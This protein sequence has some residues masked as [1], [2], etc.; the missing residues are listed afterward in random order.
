MA[1]RFRRCLIALSALLVPVSLFGQANP[2]PPKPSPQAADKKPQVG[3]AAPQSRHFPILLILS[4]T[5]PVWS[6]RI[7]MKGPELLERQG[8]P[9]ITL[10]PGE[11]SQDPAP[12]T[13]TYHAKDTA[14]GADVQVHMVREPCM[15]GLTDTKYTFR[16]E[17]DHAQI[18]TLKGC[19]RIAPDQFPEFKQKNLDDDDPEKKKPGPPPITN[20]KPPV[21]VAYL[22]PAGRAILKRGAQTHVVAAKGSELSLS[23]DGKRLLFTRDDPSGGH[24][25]LLFD[26]STGKTT[27]L[28]RGL[29]QEQQAF[30]SPD[31]S[32]IAFL[33]S[34]GA[35][36]H[37]WIA[38]SA[39]PGQAAQ[40]SATPV[41]YL[42]GWADAHTVVAANADSYLWIADDGGT[43]QAISAHD[44]CG[45]DFL[46]STA[47]PVRVSPINPDLLL[48]SA[49]LLKPP[50]G[51]P[52][53]PKTGYGSGL[54]F[55][56]IRSK[57]RSP[58]TTPDVPAAEGEWS[59]DSIQIFFTSRD[60][61][62]GPVVNRIF[63]DGSELK[64]YLV[65]SSLVVG[66]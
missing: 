32:R 51:S 10:E 24:T 25:I 19:A 23:H 29:V 47:N 41:N 12:M 1:N 15:V 11:V 18:G 5:D 14:T 22:D 17:L 37:V 13:W 40:L 46:A 57:R 56:E 2:P 48:V 39:S 26:S 58:L 35:V 60:P 65:G 21:A 54:F 3:P 28:L 38:P 4:G 6:A 20:F 49:P 44:L 64:R 42:D 16:A 34:D 52:T 9:P 30:W 63:W 45:P 36:S 43:V 33:K 31:D 27:E 50:S 62:R 7:G 55:Y 8:Y 61:R 53:D 59:R 66:Q